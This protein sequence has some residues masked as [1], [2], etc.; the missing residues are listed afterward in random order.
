[1]LRYPQIPEILIENYRLFENFPAMPPLTQAIAP[2]ASCMTST[3]RFVASG[4]WLEWVSCISVDD[5]TPPLQSPSLL[6]SCTSSCVR[7]CSRI[8]VLIPVNVVPT[9]MLLSVGFFL[10]KI[11]L[12]ADA[13]IWL[14]SSLFGE[15]FEEFL[16]R[17]RLLKAVG[18][19][20]ITL[21]EA[22]SWTQKVV[23]TWSL[24]PMTLAA[25]MRIKPIAIMKT[26]R[27]STMSMLNFWF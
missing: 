13:W 26:L 24:E 11:L 10:P 25:I 8:I 4:L 6:P 5:R 12:Q 20:A 14:R 9:L 23:H 2:A 18:Q 21:T 3:L 19:I 17:K 22:S 1:M 27:H 15:C 7:L 16:I